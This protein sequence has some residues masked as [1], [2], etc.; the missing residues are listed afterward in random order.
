MSPALPAFL[1]PLTHSHRTRLSCHRTWYGTSLQQLWAVVFVQ[2][3]PDRGPWDPSRLFY[4]DS[5]QVE[6]AYH[7]LAGDRKVDVAADLEAVVQG[8]PA[9][10]VWIHEGVERSAQRLWEAQQQA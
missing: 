10:K 9:I 4:W 8:L 3:I 6:K 7:P 2:G 1:S 5:V